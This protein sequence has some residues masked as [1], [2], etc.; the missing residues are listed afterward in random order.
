[1]QLEQTEGIVM[2]VTPFQDA[3]AIYTVYTPSMG[4]A[5]FVM[6]YGLSSRMRS[7]GAPT[8]LTKAEF[9][10]RRG[11]SDLLSCKE[12]TI[13]EAYPRIRDSLDRMESAG[14][15]LI[16]L[17]QCQPPGKD[18]PIL[19][20]LLNIYLEKLSEVED[21]RILAASFKLKILRYEGLLAYSDLCTSCKGTFADFNF[22]DGEFFC[23]QHQP[24]GSNYF[25]QEESKMFF[26]LGLSQ[27]LNDLKT[28][29]L[30]N[31]LEGKI[32]AIFE[33]FIRT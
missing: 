5:K 28:L 16:A 23:P 26:V 30:T 32:N 4:V 18:S 10:F 14:Q 3:D 33:E 2:Q 12:A 9:I 15:M 13:L 21:P 7:K 1:M 31:I 8:V 27:S 25:D 22:C 6:K 20:Q 24:K 17:R 29:A 11:K 19:Y